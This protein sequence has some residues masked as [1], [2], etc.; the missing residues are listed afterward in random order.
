MNPEILDFGAPYVP[1]TTSYQFLLGLFWGW[2]G[3]VVDFFFSRV[4][5]QT[6]DVD[7]SRFLFFHALS[8]NDF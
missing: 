6:L 2:Y 3:L 7:D 1:G 4:G 8:K 5:L